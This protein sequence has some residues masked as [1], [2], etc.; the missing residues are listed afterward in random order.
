MGWFCSS[1]LV[2]LMIGFVPRQ[3]HNMAG[4]QSPLPAPE[5][6]QLYMSFNAWEDSIED[7]SVQ[8]KFHFAVTAKDALSSH[9]YIYKYKDNQCMRLATWSK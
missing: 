7:W 3:D 1:D 9:A 2:I 8:D 5:L 4:L 6:G